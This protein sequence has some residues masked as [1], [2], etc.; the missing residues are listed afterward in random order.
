VKALEPARAFFQRS[1]GGDQ[2]LYLNFAGGH[3]LDCLRIFSGRGTGTLQANLARDNFLERKIDVG[4]DV[5]DEDDGAAFASDVDRSGDGFVAANALDS[6]VDAF[7]V[8]AL[9]NSCEQG[10]VGEKS[11]RGA[12]F[13]CECE[14]L[15]VD[16]G[17]E[18]FGATGGAQSLQREDADGA[19]ADDKRGGAWS[20]LREVDAVDCDGDGFE[21]R[22]FGERKIVRQAIEDSRGDG[23]EL[24]ESSGATI[25]GARDAEDLATIAKIYVAAAAVGTFA[26]VNGGIEG[27]TIAGRKSFYR[28][29]DGGDDTGGFVAHDDGR[30]AAARG[31]VV[32]VNVAAADAASGDADENL[33]GRRRWRGEIGELEILVAREEKGFHRVSFRL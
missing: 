30:D 10:I 19:G 28:S 18:N 11:F 21:H 23:D 33:V 3:P 25:V 4:G 2:W 31:A 24:G 15:R 12:E 26:A 1:D 16:I 7:V 27:D 9:E 22:S 20:E 32:T 17:H 29:A 13:F 5:A 14:A 6:D 8:G